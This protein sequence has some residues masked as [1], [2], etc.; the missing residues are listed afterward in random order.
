MKSPSRLVTSAAL[1][2]AALLASGPASAQDEAPAEAPSPPAVEAVVVPAPEDVPLP[3]TRP[4]V[5]EPAGSCAAQAYERARGG[6][7]EVE[8]GGRRG[9]GALVVDSSHVITL[10]RIVERGH[11][12][13]VTDAQGNRRQARIVLTADSDELVMLALDAPLPG[14]PLPIAPWEAVRVGLPVVVLGAPSADTPRGLPETFRG[15]LPWAASEG[16]VS[17]RGERAIQTDARI[18]A[19]RGG[20]IVSCAGE[21]VA[22][23][24]PT[25][26][27][28]TGPSLHSMPAVPAVADL[29]SRLDHPE[30][31]GGRWHVTGGLALGAVYEDPDWLWGG[32]LMLGLI[33]Y[34]SFLL[35]GRF[36]YFFTSFDPTGSDVAN[37]T[38]DRIRGDAY[39]AWRQ[40]ITFGRMAMYFELGAGA[41]VTRWSREARRAEIVDE[42]AGPE[43]RWVEDE[44]EDWSVR[45]M[46]VLN[47]LH[48]PMMLSYTLE[49]DIDREHVVH[50][51]NIG[52]RMH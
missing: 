35:M 9:A 1:A 40:L 29:I 48:G 17:A 43:V 34:D 22:V 16:I 42:G 36:S 11:G 23:L 52:F 26:D 38:K 8:S 30:G 47:L 28:M 3:A 33:G 5:D 51:F 45:P 31:Y 25:H 13:T 14:A 4:V 6:V 37:V 46:A 27:R 44:T 20:P 12:I 10:L 7:V 50:L 39:V 15:T 18:E 19:V 41:S 32:T 24:G 2:A 21:L 49:V